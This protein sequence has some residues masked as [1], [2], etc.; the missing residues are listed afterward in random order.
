MYFLNWVNGAFDFYRSCD[1]DLC[2]G[3]CPVSCSSFFYYLSYD[4]IC[5][6]FCFYASF[7][8]YVQEKRRSRI[9]NPTRFQMIYHLRISGPFW[10]SRTEVITFGLLLHFLRL[11]LPIDRQS[12][13][14][15]DHVHIHHLIHVVEHLRRHWQWWLKHT[16]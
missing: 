10:L 1:D 15:V 2:Y 14:L 6:I 3:F 5:A 11:T 13:L 4:L 9:R 7:S 8:A 12:T 16:H